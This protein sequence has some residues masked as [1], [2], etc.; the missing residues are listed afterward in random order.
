ML[1]GVGKPCFFQFDVSATRPGATQ[2]NNLVT[3]LKM[4]CI[5]EWLVHERC[6]A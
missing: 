1:N 5:P 3:R 6:M 2:H 4:L